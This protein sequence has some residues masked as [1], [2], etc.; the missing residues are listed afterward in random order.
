[1]IY[2]KDL[3]LGT[4]DSSYKV[5][6]INGKGETRLIEYDTIRTDG[7][8]AGLAHA[9]TYPSTPTK[10][11]FWV[12]DDPSGTIYTYFG[13]QKANKFDRFYWNG[14]SWDLVPYSLLHDY[15]SFKEIDP[16]KVGT[17]AKG[18]VFQGTYLGRIWT[19]KDSGAIQYLADSSTFNWYGVEWDVTVSSPDCTRIGNMSLHASLPVHSKIYACLLKEDGSES[20]KLNPADWGKKIT[21]EES[22]LSGVDGEVMICF[23]EYYFKS[24]V[25]G[26]IRRL[27]IS[28]YPID[29]FTH[30]PKQYIS[31]YEAGID[32]NNLKLVSIKNSDA[33]FRGGDNNP[34]NDLKD[35]TLLGMPVT[36]LSRGEFR[37]YTRAKG[38]GWQMYNYHAHKTLVNFFIIEYATRN[39]QKAVNP[40]LDASGYKQG[41]LGDG[42]TNIDK[43][44]W[45]KWKGLYPFIACG[46]SDSLGTGTGEV[47]YEMP[48]G[49]GKSLTTYVN[50]YRGVE[51]PFG[52]I[53][54]EVDG[55]NVRIAADNNADPTSKVYV[56]NDV[57]RW[58]DNM[59][60]GMDLLGQLPRTS[61]YAK[62][63]V[64][65]VPISTGGG[66][67]TYWCDF[68]NT[69]L[70]LSGEKLMSVRFGGSAIDDSTAGLVSITTVNPPTVAKA[71][72]GTRIC[73]VKESQL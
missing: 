17:P 6:A 69:S 51:L 47:A 24:E 43:R 56:S 62:E 7:G 20:Y 59:F 16:T 15:N 73:Y 58:N 44:L 41:G 21:G 23:P 61:G 70:P 36:N 35:A 9:D 55:I 1:M 64:G 29:G 49:Y 65:I 3:P 30:V 5:R 14:T 42:V 18:R 10:R 57:K 19:K 28:E 46:T 68:F 52:H 2:E 50:R 25:D 72:V 11:V 60:T 27:K 48:I 67:T 4:P 34:S 13:K 54:K 39:S 32:R 38:L 53:W 71:Y 26:N 40:A 8:Y 63:M 33:N 45:D 12:C 22:D 66:S 37:L 31:A